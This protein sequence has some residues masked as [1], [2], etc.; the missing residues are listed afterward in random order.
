MK[1]V[2]GGKRLFPKLLLILTGILIGALIAEIGLR[3]I[4]YSYPEF[5]QVDNSRGFAL[6]PGMEGWY[7]KEGSSYVRINSDG[8][9]DREHTRTKPADTMRIAVLGDSYAEAFQVPQEQAFWTV[10]ATHLQGCENLGSKKV[11]VLNFGVSGYGTAQELITLREQVWQ[12]SPDI[13]VLALTT[14]NDIADN[15][16]ALKKTDDIPYFVYQNGT[17]ALDDSFKTSR[18]FRLR[19]SL[20]NRLGRWFKDHSRLVQAINEGHHGFKALLGAWRERW[21]RPSTA[22]PQNQ[23]AGAAPKTEEPGIDNK[24]YLEPVDPVWIDA[25]NVAEQ[26]IK[27]ISVE[28]REHGARF[29]VATLSNPPQLVPDETFRQD[30][31]NRIGAVDIFYPDKRIE[32]FCKASGINVLTLAPELQH[33]ADREHAFL[34]GFGQDIGNGHWNAVGHRVAGELLAAKLCVAGLR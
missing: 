12:F 5:Y 32:S 29:F 28:V 13:V 4:G 31:L 21:T 7:Q 17:L 20:G 30:F 18:G 33:Y 25:W 1:R 16:R 26:L 9:R 34:H 22:Q 23:Q 27:Q 19:Q 3:I 14:N 15:S 11:E 24:I 10:M 8:L 2:G 6:R